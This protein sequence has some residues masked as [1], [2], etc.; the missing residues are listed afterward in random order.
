MSDTTQGAGGSGEKTEPAP[1]AQEKP[2][3]GSGSVLSQIG[4][5]GLASAALGVLGAAAGAGWPGVVA[6]AG[7]GLMLPIGWTLLVKMFNE[8]SDTRDLERAG[9]DAGKTSV[10]L[11]N[12]GREVTGNL[13]AAQKA[14]PP[15]EGFPKK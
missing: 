3:T 8:W 15:T 14:D 2:A 4:V 5:G 10:D 6:L 12:Q 9:A 1:S 13:D 7:V 11:A